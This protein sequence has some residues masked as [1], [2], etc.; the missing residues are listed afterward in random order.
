MVDQWIQ[1]RKTKK[2]NHHKV[3]TNKKPK[4]NLF[5]FTSENEI[6]EFFRF[7][8]ISSLEEIPLAKLSPFLIE[9]VFSWTNP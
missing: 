3:N 8:V 2:K 9:K 6:T 4:S 1:K 7:I 5:E